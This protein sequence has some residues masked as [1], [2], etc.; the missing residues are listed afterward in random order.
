MCD[1]KCLR[2]IAGSCTR[3]MHP[4]I[5]ARLSENGSP[6]I[7]P[8]I[9]MRHCPWSPDLAP[10]N[11][12]AFPRVKKDMKDKH[13]G[14]VEEIEQATTN[15]LKAQTVEEIQD[16]FQQWERCWAKCI[17]LEGNNFEGDRIDFD[18]DE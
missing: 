3:T 6:E 15:S 8:Y 1:L 17:E 7:E 10:N 16:C 18:D 13:W 5:T 12:W 14:T 2:R 4:L 9:V 11:F